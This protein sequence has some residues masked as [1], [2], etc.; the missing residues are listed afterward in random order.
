MSSSQ[1]YKRDIE[2]LDAKHAE[3]VIM[4]MRPVKF[5]YKQH[6]TDRW[7]FGLIAE[8]LDDVLPDAV[9]YDTDGE[10]DTLQY[11]KLPAFCIAMLQRQQAQIVELQRQMHRM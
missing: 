4:G 10:P 3:D 11:H 1:R 2:T 5:H 7:E 6:Q 8:E 9:V